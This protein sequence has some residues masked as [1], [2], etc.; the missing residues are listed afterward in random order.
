MDA[1]RYRCLFIDDTNDARSLQG[2]LIF[3]Y[4]VS[5]CYLRDSFTIETEILVYA[6]KYT[7]CK[8]SI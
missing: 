8:R 4:V 3:L 1:S 2:E 7:P 6:L 5:K